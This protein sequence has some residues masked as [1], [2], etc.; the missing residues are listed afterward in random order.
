MEIPKVN[1][2]Y[3][4][5]DQEEGLTIFFQILKILKNSRGIN[6]VKTL[7]YDLEQ[8]IYESSISCDSRMWAYSRLSNDQK[9]I[10]EFKLK[11]IQ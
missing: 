5:E 10:K 4:Y 11:K 1:G 7:E 8:R 6:I 3:L 9:K 2:Y